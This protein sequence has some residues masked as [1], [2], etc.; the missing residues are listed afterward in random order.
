MDDGSVLLVEMFGPR[1]TR[2]A[3]DGTRTTVAEIPGGPNGAAIGPDG[4]LYLCNNGGSLHAGGT[5][6]P[7]AARAVRCGPLPRW[8]DPTGGPGHGRGV[9]P[10]PRVRRPPAPF[11]QRP[12]LRRLRRVLVH[13]PRHPRRSH[14]RPH[15]HLLRPR[16]TD[17]RSGRSSFRST[18]RTASGCHRTGPCCTGPRPTRAGSSPGRSP[19]RASWLRPCPAT[20]ACLAGLSGMQRLDS[21]AVDGAGNVC[22]ATLLN[23]GITVISPAGEVLEH[24]ADRGPAHHQHLLRRAR[25]RGPPSSPPPAPGG[26]CRCRGRGP[27]WPSPTRSDAGRAPR[28]PLEGRR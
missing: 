14:E 25:P 4:A 2:I 6:R 1:V 7:A 16:R 15:G 3:P 12:G 9:R 22:V 8:P 27:A 11:A 24:V 19:V 17:R 20:S 28:T 26:C 13:R 5:R 10:L 23:G 18:R 21:L